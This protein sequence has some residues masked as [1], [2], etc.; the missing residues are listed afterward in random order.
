MYRCAVIVSLSLKY[1]VL[2]AENR[3]IE[4][5]CNSRCNHAA[6]SFVFNTYF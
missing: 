1:W 2:G 4:E 5:K 3:Q 6:K